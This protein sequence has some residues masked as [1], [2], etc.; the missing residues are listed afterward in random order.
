MPLETEA[1]P[2]DE[3]DADSILAGAKRPSGH[4]RHVTDV[5]EAQHLLTMA[6][7]PNRV[8]PA[9]GNQTLDLSVWTNELPGLGLGY[10]RLRCDVNIVSPP[11]RPSYI[12]VIP[13]RGRVLIG[14]SN[15]WWA[16]TAGRG[17]ILNPS[18]PA[19]FEQWS[20]DSCV[21]TVR[22]SHEVLQETLESLLA[23]PVTQ[24]VQF[25][26]LVDGSAQRGGPF[27]RALQLVHSELRRPDGMTKDPIMAAGLSRLLTTGLLTSQRHN[28]SDQLRAPGAAPGPPGIRA[29]VELIEARPQHVSAVTDIAAAAALSVRALEEG[30]K[31]HLGISP[32]GY[33]RDVRLARIH[34]DLK[35]SDPSMTTASAIARRWGFNHYG[36]FAAIYRQRY[37]VSPTVT[38]GKR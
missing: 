9:G 13:T 16:A 34:N 36:R 15:E 2:S 5:D 12:A 38:L 25:E 3:Q 1:V 11:P 26:T 21:L 14:T 32:M 35:A 19:Y 30:F 6:Y 28:Y 24:P 10:S 20:P 37:G 31:K 18:K 8:C 7:A 4:V 23:R 17:V 29:A 22:I 33:V 27:L